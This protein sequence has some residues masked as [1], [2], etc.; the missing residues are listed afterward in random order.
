MNFNN[1][2]VGDK[3]SRGDETAVL[4]M[5]VLLTPYSPAD[6][7]SGSSS[8]TTE[9]RQGNPVMVYST[10]GAAGAVTTAG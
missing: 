10:A 5:V 1:C 9:Q 6:I 8:R 3:S 7:K 2:C 4:V